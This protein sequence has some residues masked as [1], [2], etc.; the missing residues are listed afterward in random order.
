M[1]KPAVSPRKIVSGSKMSSADKV[2][3]E[4]D[5]S[6]TNNDLENDPDLEISLTTQEIAKQ[7]FREKETQLYHNRALPFSTKIKL[8][9]MNSCILK[10]DEIEALKEK[11]KVDLLP[12]MELDDQSIIFFMNEFV[13]D[14]HTFGKRI[15]KLVKNLT[16]KRVYEFKTDLNNVI[17]NIMS[18]IH[19]HVIYG[20]LFK[21]NVENITQF[22]RDFE[23]KGYKL[24]DKGMIIS[25]LFQAVFQICSVL[26]ENIMDNTIHYKMIFKLIM[27]IVN[28]ELNVNPN[29]ILKMIDQGSSDM[30]LRFF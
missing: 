2:E 16:K 4:A 3:S 18:D 30:T 10:K 26:D 19:N 11:R 28:T 20:N 7:I 12:K 1:S 17:N 8:E 24:F 9:I 27:K 6:K 21:I 14:K 25:S 15:L 29:E 23:K 22:V 13:S 5:K